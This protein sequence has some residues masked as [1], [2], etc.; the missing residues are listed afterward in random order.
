MHEGEATIQY[1]ATTPGFPEP[2][3]EFS[4]MLIINE[5]LL[6]NWGIDISQNLVLERIP[7]TDEGGASKKLDYLLKLK[8]FQVE[9]TVA[10]KLE[11]NAEKLREL[12]VEH[13]IDKLN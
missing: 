5:Y 2:K 7:R 13:I 1:R 10:E 3:S 4:H 12:F 8:E 6:H 11:D 9:M